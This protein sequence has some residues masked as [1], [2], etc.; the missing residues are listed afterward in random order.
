MMKYGSSL[1][2][3]YSSEV[4]RIFSSWNGPSRNVFKLPWTTHRYLIEAVSCSSHPK[5]MLCSRLMRFLETLKICTKSIV[6][7]LASLVQD[8]R[9]TLMGRTLTKFAFDSNVERGSLTTRI[10][11]KM[12]YSTPPLDEQWRVPLLRELLDV[13]DGRAAIP[14]ADP[15]HIDHMISEICNN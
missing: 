15:Q 12:R 7:Y 4:T 11:R 9:R 5:T 3:L 10:I 1:C 8:D 6:R 13:R 2:D 14:G